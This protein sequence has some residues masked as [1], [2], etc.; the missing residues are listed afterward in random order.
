MILV[1]GARGNVGGER[2]VGKGVGQGSAFR[3]AVGRRGQ[4]RDEG[5]FLLHS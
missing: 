2:R 4:G 1:T 3:R 5:M